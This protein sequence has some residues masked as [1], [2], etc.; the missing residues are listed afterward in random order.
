MSMVQ[1]D[2]HRAAISLVRL[3]LAALIATVVVYP[4]KMRLFDA[5]IER[6]LDEEMAAKIEEINRLA[7]LKKEEYNR[8]HKEADKTR[9]KRY[10]VSMLK[11]DIEELERQW[12][13]C[14]KNLDEPIDFHL[15][16]C[17]GETGKVLKNDDPKCS[18]A[19]DAVVKKIAEC[20]LLDSQIAEGKAKINRKLEINRKLDQYR[21]EITRWENRKNKGLVSIGM[22]AQG[23]IKAVE[24]K[25]PH[26]SHS[27]LGRSLALSEIS[28]KDTAVSNTI[29]MV[30]LLFI[31]L[32]CSPILVRF[33]SPVTAYEAKLRE[34]QKEYHRVSDKMF[35]RLNRVVEEK[36]LFYSFSLAMFATIAAVTIAL[37]MPG[38]ENI[39]SA[40]VSIISS[41]IAIAISLKKNQ[42]D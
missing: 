26:L 14:W 35:S 39:V 29:L 25:Y 12:E 16:Q 24:E 15:K 30:T 27:F 22:E 10:G 33:S 2:S 6:Y 37:I 5:E 18:Q 20:D 34:K 36:V 13:V 17:A 11:T 38:K 41:T 28:D 8:L 19:R 3:V 31:T 32:Q 7:E 21:K 42:T 9:Q 4:I 40:V 23:K 1:H